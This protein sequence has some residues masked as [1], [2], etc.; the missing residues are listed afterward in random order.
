MQVIV[1]GG[2]GDMGS[3]AVE[4]L[5]ASEGVRGVT[6]T[7][8]NVVAAQQVAARLAGSAAQMDV[9]P[10]DANNHPELVEA[11]GGYDSPPR[12]WPGASC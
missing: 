2:A 3:R 5:A 1:L 9:R 4:D 10:V 8:R 12:Y 11:M 7:D 6:I